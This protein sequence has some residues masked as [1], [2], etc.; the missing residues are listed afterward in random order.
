VGSGS[1]YAIAAARALLD[2]P[3]MSAEDI[4]RKAM[5]VAAEM[6]VYT[7]TEFLVE[8]IPAKPKPIT[9]APD[10]GK[11]TKNSNKNNN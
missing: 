8:T 4:C 6:C 11:K 7:N 3:K 10:G 2:Q 5:A 1:P 9:I